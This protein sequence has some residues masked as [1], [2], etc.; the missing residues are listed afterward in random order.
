RVVVTMNQVVNDAGMAWMLRENF[1][2]H[3][4]GAHISGEIAPVLSSAQDGQRIEGGGI[5]VFRKFTVQFRE[6]GFVAAV[7]LFLRAL[8]K[9]DFNALKVEFFSLRRSFSK[10]RFWSE[11]EPVQN[12][13][14]S[15]NILLMPERMIFCHGF[16]PKSQ[17]KVRS[18]LLNFAKVFS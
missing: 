16:A 4:G 7:T 13:A 11:R 18:D 6:H 3:G 1:F 14:S 2:E 5:Y 15:S 17:S 9:E 8:A 12:L 10:A